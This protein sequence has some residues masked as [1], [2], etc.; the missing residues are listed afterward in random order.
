M[1]G[2]VIAASAT[3]EGAPE[4]TASRGPQGAASTAVAIAE[5]K[6]RGLVSSLPT[7]RA[8]APLSTTARQP[9]VHEA[10]AEAQGEYLA[11][12]AASESPGELQT[13]K[14][15]EDGSDAG[16]DGA[17]HAEEYLL[18]ELGSPHRE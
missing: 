3:A 15:T 4:T 5:L 16:G 12:T 7:K 18:G 1:R 13:P 10:M 6:T 8:G 9:A 11:T 14:E 2:G 17:K